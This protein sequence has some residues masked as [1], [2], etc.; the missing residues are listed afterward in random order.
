MRLIRT[1]AIFIVCSASLSRADVIHFGAGSISNQIN[2]NSYRCVID[3]GNWIYNAGVVDPGIAGCDAESYGTPI[4]TPTELLPQ[5]VYPA[6][7]MHTATHRWWG[8]VA[9]YGEMPV[10]DETRAGY[11][12]PDPIMARITDRGFRALGIPNGLS[13]QS[14]NAFNYTVPDPHS[15]VFDGIAIGNSDY[16]GLDAFMK[17][18]SDGSVT[19]E[20][21]SGSTPV[22]EATFIYGSPYVFVDVEEGTPVIRT[23]SASGAEKEVFLQEDN[24]LGV[25][26]NVAGHRN[27]FLIV[28]NDGAYFENIDDSQMSMRNCTE[29]TLAL[30]PVADDEPSSA[31]I[32]AVQQ[33][34]RNRVASVSINY[35]VDKDSQKVT[36][37]QQYLDA[38]GQA[39]T[40]L[41]GLMPLQ[42]K[43]TT[44]VTGPYQV[45]SARGIVRF[46][47]TSGFEYSLPFVGVLPM[48]PLNESSLDMA[49]LKQLILEFVEQGE[50][51]WN[52]ASDT[53]WAGKN[54]AKIAELSAI[55]RSIDMTAEANQLLNYLKSE[56]EDWFVADSSGDLDVTK[57]FVYD[58]QWNTLLGLD[59]SYGSHQE[60]NDH[61]F[62]YGYFVRAAAEICRVDA[63]WCG[64]DAYG[65]M[66]ELLIRD[67]AAGRDDSLFPYLRNFDPANGFSWASGHANFTLGNN[68]ES[69]SEAA[70]AYG[71]MILYGLATGNSELVERGVYL[72]ASTTA[73]FWEYWNN[74]DRYRGLDKDY[75]N[76]PEDYERITT[77][78][79]WGAGATFSTW[80]SS[81]YAHILG[82]Q[83]L[84]LNPLT[85][86]LGLH[87]DYLADY[88]ELGLSESS[89]GL[90]SGLPDDQWCDIWWNILAMTSPRSAIDD[91]NSINFDYS[92]ESGET[93]AHTYHWIHAMNSLGSVV[94]G[95]DELS[96]DNP[97]AI[98]FEKDGLV[99]YV[100]YNYEA[101]NQYVRFSDGMGLNVPP[102]KFRVLTSRDGE[103]SEGADD[104]GGADDSEG[105]EDLESVEGSEGEQDLESVD[106]SDGKEDEDTIEAADPITT[107]VQAEDYVRYFDTSS[108]NSG[109]VY[110]QDDVD[111]E[112]TDDQGGGYHIGWADTNEWLEYDLDLPTGNYRLEARVASLPG[113]GAYAVYLNDQLI[114]ADMV[115]ATGGWQS[116]ETHALG[117]AR[118]Q[119]GQN[120]LRVAVSSGLFNLNWL[121]FVSIAEEDTGSDDVKNDQ[122]NSA[123]EESDEQ[124]DSND[125]C[126]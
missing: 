32:D 75:D 18:Y 125:D 76:F 15:E 78:I 126:I 83:G 33:L 4:G 23:K 86:R 79:I 60:L 40:T 11:I 111:I 114:A 103:D 56:L 37:Q 10:E 115:D 17:D 45:R 107:T 88:A 91:F 70:N 106:D 72:H 26:T 30:L 2:P 20:W 38:Q 85:L 69:T 64:E 112:S 5:L 21:Q 36:V 55:A 93:K 97:S 65:P 27:Y 43:N 108:G 77:S 46:T 29:F 8:S 12:T 50:S 59:E 116:F 84:P 7:N 41:A 122:E 57:Y 68:N 119:D 95:K 74:I 28:A 109:G 53:Y 105:E 96:A 117:K 98:A 6:A 58:D 49:Q 42:W 87:T 110:R 92:P 62:H 54:Y 118:V 24:V 104:S 13:V 47:P 63:A 90:P 14:E 71:S 51:S 31:M 48:L 82:I 66:V 81:A 35:S 73:S 19:V 3:N 44:H 34:A 22:M 80:F 124:Q 113:G 39:V 121:R 123:S 61:H 16:A 120:T 9:F 99:T 89:N 25:S 1:L 52:S 101:E 100:A 67:Y 102:G 94:T